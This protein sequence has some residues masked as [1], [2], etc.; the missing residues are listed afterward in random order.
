MT[1]ARSPGV[2]GAV[3]PGAGFD[4]LVAALRRLLAGR[5][6]S[7][8]ELDFR[9]R[10]YGRAGTPATSLSAF[11]D[12]YRAGGPAWSYE[13]QAMIKLRAIAGDPEPIA[14]VE[15]LRDQ[16][17]YGPEPFDLASCRR[18][19]QMQFEQNVQPGR[20]NA[21]LSPGALVDVEYFVQAMQIAHGGR[22]PSVRTPNTQH[23]IAALEAAGL[24]GRSEAESLRACYRF[25]RTLIDALRVVHGHAQ[26]LTVPPA[27]AEE[28]I[29]LAPP[30]A[31]ARGPRTYGRDPAPARADARP[32]ARVEEFVGPVPT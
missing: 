8:F 11:A 10:P 31:P 24:L 3:S 32:C 17:V 15:R 19:R 7:T 16:F 12:Y 27:D 9:L 22:V 1:T 29:L 25:F 14:A 5:Q 13:R 21:K 18:M 30:D 20:I 2:A 6:G 26:D 23:A 4:G 28:Y